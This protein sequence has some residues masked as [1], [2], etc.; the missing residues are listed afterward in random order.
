MMFNAFQTGLGTAVS[1]TEF[2]EI[3]FSDEKAMKNDRYMRYLHHRYHN[4]NYGES[5][6]P[7]DKWFGSLHDGSAEADL[8]FREM[9]KLRVRAQQG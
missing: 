3:V 2:D 1:H 5:N 4:V 6:V 9:H 7:M 8:Y